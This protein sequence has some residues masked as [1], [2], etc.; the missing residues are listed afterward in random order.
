MSII[1]EE[2]T[3]KGYA[4]RTKMNV[5][6]TDATVAFAVD[7]STGG[8]KITRKLCMDLNKPFLPIKIDGSILNSLKELTIFLQNHN[9]EK[10]NI[11]GNGIYTFRKHNNE[12]ST[13]QF[14]L[15]ELIFRC[16]KTVDTSMV[17][18][19]QSGGQTGVDESAIKAGIKLK[20]PTKIIAPKGWMFRGFDG[21]DVMDEIKF[22]ERFI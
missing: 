5:K 4:A 11:A 21:K 3:V 18:L 13:F 20:I 6:E 19:I 10:L 14:A 22:K 1:F 16:L 9:I 2:C 7:F 8:E 12:S 15:D 17:K